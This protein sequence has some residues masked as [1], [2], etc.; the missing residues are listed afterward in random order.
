MKKLIVLCFT[1][2]ST[3][4]ISAQEEPNLLI[5]PAPVTH[6]NNLTEI[7]TDFQHALGVTSA[8]FIQGKTETSQNILVSVEHILTGLLEISKCHTNCQ[9]HLQKSYFPEIIFSPYSELITSLDSQYKDIIDFHKLLIESGST[10]AKINSLTLIILITQNLFEAL[11]IANDHYN[12]FLMK[13]LCRE[14]NAQRSRL[15]LQAE[16]YFTEYR[17][18]WRKNKSPAVRE[19]AISKLLHQAK[20]FD[21]FMTRF[22]FEPFD[23]YMPLLGLSEAGAPEDFL[24]QGWKIHISAKP[25]N[26]HKV[27]E[28]ILPILARMKVAHKIL[29]SIK[30]LE[31][32]QSDP[33][34]KGKFITIY[35]LNDN[36]A[37]H[38]ATVLDQALENFKPDD[39]DAP[40]HDALIGNTGGIFTRYGA[41]SGM[42]LVVI[43]Q[44]GEAQITEDG[45]YITINDDRSNGYKP[46]F[47]TWRSPF[48]QLLKDPSSKRKSP[49][50]RTEGKRSLTPSSAATSSA[51]TSSAEPINPIKQPSFDATIAKPESSKTHHR[52]ET[53]EQKEKISEF[54]TKIKPLLE[55]YSRKS[56]LL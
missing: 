11:C 3:L 5:A 29:G 21:E 4:S 36:Q 38:I 54:M 28:R 52:R 55:K 14:P 10:S 24:R 34:Q 44:Q 17:E 19:T 53:A 27:A 43:N 40:P 7:I 32:I 31:K 30:I 50:K 35:P 2:L 47:V 16:P 49:L 45:S 20:D 33:V 6:Q 41:Y 51:A 12:T 26:A 42:S 37:F 39:F 25:E 48:G 8:L 15:H 23:G 56:T 46:N 18:Q 13:E 1:F 22:V 9:T